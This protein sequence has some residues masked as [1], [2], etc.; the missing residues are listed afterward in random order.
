MLV[1][2]RSGALMPL[3]RAHAKLYLYGGTGGFME[4]YGRDR[5]VKVLF[6]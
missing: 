3:E 1:W 4:Q 2:R 5:A 6:L